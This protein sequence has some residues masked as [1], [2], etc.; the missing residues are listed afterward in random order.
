[1]KKNEIRTRREKDET[2]GQEDGRTG[3]R[4]GTCFRS[5]AWKSDQRNFWR[6]LRRLL[7]DFLT[8]QQKHHKQ[9]R[10]RRA[11]Q[12]EQLQTTAEKG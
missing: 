3:G 4:D 11:T 8:I 7:D 5:K 2:A 6:L 10:R 9:M 1:M 12:Q